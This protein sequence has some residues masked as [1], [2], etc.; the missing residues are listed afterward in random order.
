MKSLELKE[1]Q[2]RAKVLYH[3]KGIK[4]IYGNEFGQFSYRVEDL[5]DPHL[6]KEVKVWLFNDTGKAPENLNKET[7]VIDMTEDED[8]TGEKTPDKEEDKKPSKKNKK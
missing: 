1:L 2:R 7:D 6:P 3:D 8:D 5:T 4:A